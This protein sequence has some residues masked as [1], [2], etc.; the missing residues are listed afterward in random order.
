MS[1]NTQVEVTMQNLQPWEDRSCNLVHMKETKT[2][3]HHQLGPGELL[4]EQGQNCGQFYFIPMVFDLCWVEQCIAICLPVCCDFY[5]QFQ[6]LFVRFSISFCS[7]NRYWGNL[8]TVFKCPTAS[9]ELVK[10]DW[11]FLA[12]SKHI[13]KQ[14]QKVI[15]R[16]DLLE[17]NPRSRQLAGKTQ[18]ENWDWRKLYRFHHSKVMSH[19]F[20]AI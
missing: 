10:S 11:Y 12:W 4:Y 19:F 13:S 3:P 18:L 5:L 2:H 17:K 20:N 15:L 16:V 6:N 8:E 1:I 9:P 7:D 14:K